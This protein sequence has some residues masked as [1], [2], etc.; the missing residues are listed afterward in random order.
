ME[1]FLSINSG[2]DF[3]NKYL[4]LNTGVFFFIKSIE[5]LFS[6]FFSC[7]FFFGIKSNFH[8]NAIKHR[9]TMVST[10]LFHHNEIE[11]RLKT[12]G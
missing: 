11:S 7:F 10:F 4:Q 1:W 3:L 5:D 12:I 8:R 2:Y 6:R 9:L